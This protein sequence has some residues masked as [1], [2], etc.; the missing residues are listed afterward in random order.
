MSLLSDLVL[1]SD[2]YCRATG[3]SR[4]RVSTLVLKSGRRLDDLAQGRSDIQWFSDHWPDNAD[5]PA[6]VDRPSV[7]AGE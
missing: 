2:S 3:L 7:E 5:W 1:L 4:A 6:E